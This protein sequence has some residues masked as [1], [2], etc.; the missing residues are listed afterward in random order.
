MEV[1]WKAPLQTKG[2]LKIIEFFIALL[3]LALVAGFSTSTTADCRFAG[4]E[5]NVTAAFSASYPFGEYSITTTAHHFVGA[6]PSN[7]TQSRLLDPSI[8]QTAQ[9]FVVWGSFTM[10]YSVVAILVYMFITANE[11]L[12]K[13]F[14]FL[15]YCDLVFHIV[16]V[17]CWFIASVEWAVGYHRL[18]GELYGVVQSFGSQCSNIV[19]GLYVQAAI[20]VVFGFLLFF[21][22]A[23]NIF[24]VVIDTSIYIRWRRSRGAISYSDM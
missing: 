8:M 22:W 15:V 14:D 6:I 10:I 11:Q 3:A 5:V 18:R 2:F 1:H 20:A 19:E 17:V 9:F 21:L 24:W 4:T 13:V 16:W 7:V 23:V 12:E